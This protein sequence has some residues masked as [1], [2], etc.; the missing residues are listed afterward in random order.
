LH[1][2]T[3]V[4]IYKEAKATIK[5]KVQKSA[6]HQNHRKLLQW[7]QIEAQQMP[8]NAMKME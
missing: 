7:R 8:G 6:M 5:Y 2:V 3:L 1:T 4:E